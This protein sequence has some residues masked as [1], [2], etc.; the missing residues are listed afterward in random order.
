MERTSHSFAVGLVV[1]VP[2]NATGSL[3]DG[4]RRVLERVEVVEVVDDPQVRG[5]EP[6]L[7]DITVEL[8]VRLELSIDERGEDTALARRRLESGVGVL[9]VERVDALA[10]TPDNAVT[11]CGNPP[12]SPDEL[13][14]ESIER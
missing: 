7:N 4:A 13:E 5:L 1:R 3:V 9:T 10:S 2:I 12:T 14:P 11:V 8:D 6:G